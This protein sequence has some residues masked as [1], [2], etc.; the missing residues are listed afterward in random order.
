MYA[1]WL[2]REH[3]LAGIHIEQDDKWVYLCMNNACFV[4][5]NKDVTIMKL[6]KEADMLLNITRKE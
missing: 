5:L 4:Q 2:R 3:K 1:Q 6:L